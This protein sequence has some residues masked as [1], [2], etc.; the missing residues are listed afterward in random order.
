MMEV[1]SN[2][3]LHS[4]VMIIETLHDKG[5]SVTYDVEK[6]Q[7]VIDVPTALDGKCRYI[8]PAGVV[9]EQD[10]LEIKIALM[11]ICPFLKY[12][13]PREVYGVVEACCTSISSAD[14]VD[15]DLSE[16]PHCDNCTHCNTLQEKVIINKDDGNVVIDL[17]DQADITALYNL[18][19]KFIE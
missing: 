13:T 5:V 1:T 6:V 10:C 8:L 2:M 16:L 14:V 15:D 18:L 9:C 19:E 17:S 4:T 3:L 11:N 12:L 7:Y